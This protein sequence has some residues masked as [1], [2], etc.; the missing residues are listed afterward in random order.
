MGDGIFTEAQYKKFNSFSFWLFV[1][2]IGG[3]YN[4][5]YFFLLSVLLCFKD[6]KP[7]VE[8]VS[9]RAFVV[10]CI[11][12]SVYLFKIA[13]RIRQ[14]K[15]NEVS[16]LMSAV[17]SLVVLYKIIGIVTILSI[18]VGLVLPLLSWGLGDFQTGR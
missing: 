3:V 12:L 11:V 10:A 8:I 13:K 2:G 7:V 18:I 6:E 5:V 9:L 1:S 15:N 17:D 4:A 16:N 14:I